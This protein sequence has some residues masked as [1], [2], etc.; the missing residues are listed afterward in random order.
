[1]LQNSDNYMEI[2]N[3]SDS[4]LDLLKSVKSLQEQRVM[5]Y[6]S[7]EKYLFYNIVVIFM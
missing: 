4:L 1:M 7:F 6:K 2:G 3:N 5:I